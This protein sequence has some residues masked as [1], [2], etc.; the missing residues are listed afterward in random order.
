[1]TMTFIDAL[2]CRKNLRLFTGFVCFLVVCAVLPAKGWSRVVVSDMVALQGEK[3]MLR[4]ETKGKIFHKGGQ[5]VEFLIGGKSIGRTLSGGDGVAFKPF[6][7]KE[8]G[9]REILVKSGTEEGKGLL[10]SLK[11]GSDIVFVDVVGSLLEGR[12]SW[13]PK[14]GSQKAVEEISKA[15]P[16]VFLQRG[17]IGVPLVREWLEDNQF[18][19]RPVLPWREGRLLEELVEMG[20]TIHAVVGNEALIESARTYQP[21]SF[22]FQPVENAEWVKDWEEIWSKLKVEKNRKR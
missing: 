22:S 2:T 7:P 17:V 19:A 16:L 21:L 11:K 14:V 4:A 6:T 8:K 10:L 3:V 20:L 18:V 12:L 15:F 5:L 9:L 1:M 13:E